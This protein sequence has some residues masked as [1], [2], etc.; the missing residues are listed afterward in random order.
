MSALEDLPE[1]AASRAGPPALPPVRRR[2]RRQGGARAR[3]HDDLRR[4]EL[5]RRRDRLD[6]RRSRHV[7]E[8]QGQGHLRARADQLGRPARVHDRRAEERLAA[9][10]P[11]D[12]AGRPDDRGA[13]AADAAEGGARRRRA[14][15]DPAAGGA[16]ALRRARRG[17]AHRPG[18]RSRAAARG[19]GRRRAARAARHRARARR[20][21]APR[22]LEGH[23]RARRRRA[24]RRRGGR[25]ER[26]PPCDRVRSRHDDGR[27]DAARPRDRA[28][29]GGAV[30]PERA[31]AVRRGCDL[32]DLGDHDGRRR[33]RDA[34]A[35]CARD[36]AEADRRGV[37]GS[38][39]RSRP[40][41]TRS[42]SPATRR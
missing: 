24:D 2:P 3:G 27:R 4:R 21:A 9:R 31:A 28:A 29:E 30:D 1:D 8:V 26:Q 42:S 41:C 10:V 12:D 16:E 40:R 39:R 15:R 35:A 25:H 18:V 37:R 6:L 7:Q 36:A 34:A 32:A 33:A 14:P 23:R 20:H 19:D 11:R 38:R 17:D 13:A 5:E 22:E